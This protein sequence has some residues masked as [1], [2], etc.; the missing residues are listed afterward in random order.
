MLDSMSTVNFGRT[1]TNTTSGFLRDFVPKIGFRFMAFARAIG[2][3]EHTNTTI[4]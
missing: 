1:K 3:Q 2:L 4:T